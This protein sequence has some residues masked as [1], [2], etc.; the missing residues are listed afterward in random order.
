M[1]NLSTGTYQDPCGQCNALCCRVY[2]IEK[3]AK[4]FT[5]KGIPIKEQ[6]ISCT[7]LD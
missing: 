6:N 1:L 5:F 4:P 3:P 2:E 7:H